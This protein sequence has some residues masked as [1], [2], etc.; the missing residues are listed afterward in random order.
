MGESHELVVII[1]P[2]FKR[3]C[4]ADACRAAL[5]NHLLYW[6]ARKAKGEPE[7]K[8]KQGE[9]YWYGTAEE[10]CEGMDN[11]WSVN[12]VRKE[13]KELVDAGLIGQRLNEGMQQFDEESPIRSSI[14]EDGWVNKTFKLPHF[15]FIDFERVAQEYDGI[16]LTEQGNGA[17]HLSYP[18]DLNGWDAESV[19]W[20]R[21]C[22]SQVERIETP[23]PVA[24]ASEE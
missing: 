2:S 4:G 5:F 23:V 20:F 10:I 6:I 18:H 12:K 16:W 21:W 17:T 22:F 7:E 9:I 8:V 24:V 11:S 15:V 14:F 3:F 19:L 13:I 1:R